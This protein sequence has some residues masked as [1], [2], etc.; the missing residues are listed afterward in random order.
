MSLPP[1]DTTQ[2]GYTY[3]KII[4][5][6]PGWAPAQPVPRG[7]RLP[8]LNVPW[9]PTHD[10]IL[11]IYWLAAVMS[12][13][14]LS[15]LEQMGIMR[16]DPG[17]CELPWV[18]P[19]H[20]ALRI[21]HKTD[22]T[23]LTEDLHTRVKS[24][25]LHIL[26]EPSLYSAVVHHLP[27]L[28]EETHAQ[29][30]G[31][32]DDASASRYHQSELIHVPYWRAAARASLEELSILLGWADHPCPPCTFPPFNFYG[33]KNLSRLKSDHLDK[34][35]G[36]I[37]LCFLTLHPV[38]DTLKEILTPP[39]EECRHEFP[40]S[41]SCTEEGTEVFVSHKVKTNLGE[42]GAESSKSLGVLLCG[43]PA[44]MPEN[45]KA[46]GLDFGRDAYIMEYLIRDASPSPSAFLALLL[47][48]T[49]FPKSCTI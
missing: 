25:K 40:I 45:S 16:E 2:D 26:H 14:S 11:K 13:V 38:L 48:S 42:E 28:I 39:G 19:P 33:V 10:G 17:F 12:T 30:F 24:L 21:R 49:F 1:Y 29:P 3:P 8:H 44:I 32:G 43:K 18:V 15:M 20:R 47:M 22:A 5:M 36:P 31:S 46:Y 4:E 9:A 34:D 6:E 41:L 23:R 7:R 35:G 27:A 37:L